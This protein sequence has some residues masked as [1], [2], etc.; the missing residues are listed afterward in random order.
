MRAA[1]RDPD[2]Y[3]L[4]AAEYLQKVRETGD[5]G[6]LPARRR[7]ARGARWRWPR[8]IAGALTERGALR[9]ARHD[10]ARR[11]RATACART[12]SARRWSGPTACSS[13][14]TS[15][16]AATG[17]AERALQ[18][19][20]DLKPDLAALLARVL[21]PRAARRPGRRAWRRCAL[22]VSA[23]GG[24]PENAAYVGTL[25]GNLRVR[26]RPPRRRRAPPTATRCARFPALRPARAPG[27]RA[28]PPP[29]GRTARGDPD[30]ARRGARA[31]A[32][33][34]RGRARARR[35]SPPAGGRGPRATSRWCAPSRRCCGPA[36]STTDTELA[37]FE[38]SHGDPARAVALA[39]AA[40][41]PRRACAPPTRSA[42]R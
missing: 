40:W 22:A 23:G 38:A 9:L 37:L 6:L 42:G 2:G 34:A 26:A 3:T 39:Q 29:R 14:P 11:A 20:I 13:T 15:S 31:A 27:S 25:L 8:A 28:S 16:S 18:R 12:G 24:T 35:S 19:M 10:F 36:A 17:E 7:R 1:P 33:R 21:L 5:A 32:A 41:A 30:A 4:L